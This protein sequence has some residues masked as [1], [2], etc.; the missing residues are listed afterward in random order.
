M[1]EKIITERELIE[2]IARATCRTAKDIK[3]VELRSAVILT[4]GFVAAEAC[5]ILFDDEEDQEE[6][7]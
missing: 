4:N 1:K 5:S 7:E 6:K 2:A 3:N